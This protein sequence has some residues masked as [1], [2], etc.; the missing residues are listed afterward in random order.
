MSLNWCEFERVPMYLIANQETPTFFELFLSQAPVC[1]YKPSVPYELRKL[2]GFPVRGSVIRPV[3]YP[4]NILS[5]IWYKRPMFEIFDLF[6]KSQTP[7]IDILANPLK[8]FI[9][10][11][12]SPSFE[13]WE[14]I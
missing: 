14:Y 5:P 4:V 11:V 12:T 8:G 7:S 1:K 6:L 9:K 3:L 10:F 2:I 13:R